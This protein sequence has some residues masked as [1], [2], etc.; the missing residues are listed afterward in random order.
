M[1]NKELFSGN[2]FVCCFGLY[3]GKVVFILEVVLLILSKIV[4]FLLLLFKVL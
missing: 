4:W 3:L 2:F 1:D